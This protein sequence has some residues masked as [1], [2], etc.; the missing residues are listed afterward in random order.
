MP[1]ATSQKQGALLEAAA[2]A[3]GAGFGVDHDIGRVDQSRAD[4]RQQHQQGGRRVT[5]GAGD[6]PAPGDVVAIEFAQA[7]D[8]FRLQM[9]R[10]VR[11]AVPRGVGVHVA[12]P[13]IGRHVG[14]L[15]MRG[16]AGDDFLGRAVGQAADDDVAGVPV[17]LRDGHEI[18]QLDHAEM[19]EHGLHRLAG[20]PVGGHQRDAQVRVGQ[21]QAHEIGAGVAAGAEDADPDLVFAHAVDPS[22]IRPM[23][24]RPI[25]AGA[26]VL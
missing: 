16:Q 7:V 20:M 1:S 14:D 24:F 6:Q 17:R 23:I 21:D 11:M 10:P 4:Q 18:R 22:S 5:A 25:P 26:D 12:Q 13:E 19:R 9:R 2:G 15:Q 3:G 8:R